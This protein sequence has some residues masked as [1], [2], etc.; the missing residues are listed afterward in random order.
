MAKETGT[1]KKIQRSPEV[2][3]SETEVERLRKYQVG[4]ATMRQV[5]I[6]AGR[7]VIKITYVAVITK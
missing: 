5:G 1:R 6:V 3:I 7:K 2:E 4:E